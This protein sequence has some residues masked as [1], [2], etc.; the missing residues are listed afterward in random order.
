MNLS[1]RIEIGGLDKQNINLAQAYSGS[2]LRSFTVGRSTYC[3]LRER[4]LSKRDAKAW[5][6]AADGPTENCRYVCCNRRLQEISGR[7][8]LQTTSLTSQPEP[9]ADHARH[10]YA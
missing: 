4:R 5:P 1:E 6:T 10:F 3:G 8:P 2:L 7:G 9:D